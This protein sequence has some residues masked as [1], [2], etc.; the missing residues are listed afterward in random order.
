MED[1][2]AHLIQLS[3]GNQPER[4]QLY[5][6]LLELEVECYCS[7]SQPLQM[8]LAGAFSAIQAWSVLRQ[9]YASPERLRQWLNQCWQLDPLPSHG[10]TT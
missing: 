7:G 4:W 2:Q 10:E 9:M 1:L 8:H 3:S 6:R 5:N